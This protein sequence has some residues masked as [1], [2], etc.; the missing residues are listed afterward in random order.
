[1]LTAGRRRG[2][3]LPRAFQRDL[4]VC[5]ST[6]DVWCRR[7]RHRG[8]IAEGSNASDGHA[9]LTPGARLPDEHSAAC[10]RRSLGRRTWGV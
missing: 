4:D 3:T 5:V 10:T 6:R 1:M 8:R 2:E 7:I 9:I